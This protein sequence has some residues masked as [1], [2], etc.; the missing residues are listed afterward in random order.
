MSIAMVFGAWFACAPAHAA[1]SSVEACIKAARPATAAQE[2]CIGKMSSACI[3]PDEGAR[4]DGDVIGCLDGEQAQWDRLLNAAYQAMMKGLEPEQQT[5][6][7]DMQRSW[8]ETRKKTCDF[9]YD[10]FQGSMAYPMIANC[11]NRETA[12]RAI[13]L[14][15]FA[16]DIADR[17]K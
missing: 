14:R 15:G 4:S 5:K 17:I 6:L 11:M 3:G 12:R 2:R 9:Y 8:I 7:R 13:Y 10:Y 1:G 16:N